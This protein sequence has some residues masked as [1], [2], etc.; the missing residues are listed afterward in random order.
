[1][2]APQHFGLYGYEASNSHFEILPGSRPLVV[3]CFQASKSRPLWFFNRTIRTEASFTQAL[4]QRLEQRRRTVQRIQKQNTP[5]DNSITS[6]SESSLVQ[7]LNQ[8]LTEDTSEAEE[9]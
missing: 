6:A 5:V 4:N 3:A 2:Q 7:R 8:I 9:L 1:M